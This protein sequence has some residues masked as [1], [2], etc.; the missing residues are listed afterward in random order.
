MSAPPQVRVAF[1][2]E[3]PRV[4]SVLTDAFVDEMGL[5]YWLRQDRAKERARRLF[6]DAAVR[7]V[8]H[9][10]RTLWLAAGDDQAVGAALWL[11]P[12]QHAFE[13]GFWRQ[14]ALAPLL[15]TV[16]GVTGALRGLSLSERISALHPH[17]PHAHLVF[18]GVAPAAQGR[19]VGSAMLKQTLSRLDAAGTPALL[20]AT[21]E[22]NVALY[23]R[24]GFEVIENLHAPGLHVR[25][26]WRTPR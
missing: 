10:Q 19:G 11:A 5:N 13:L 7:D 9:P 1:D 26:M 25:I 20:E 23:Q 12:G 3:A 4:A 24:H 15:W 6:F 17:Q 22:R 18:L 8:V 21:T 16:A 14:V 2:D